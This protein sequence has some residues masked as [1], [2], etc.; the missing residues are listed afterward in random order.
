MFKIVITLRSRKRKT[1]FNEH[2]FWK[3][4][5]QMR[6]RPEKLAKQ[7]S[8][9]RPC[10]FCFFF[11][12]NFLLWIEKVCSP[13]QHLDLELINWGPVGCLETLTVVK[14]IDKVPVLYWR[15]TD[16]LIGSPRLAHK[17]TTARSNLM[18]MMSLIMVCHCCWTIWTSLLHCCR[19]NAWLT[20]ACRTNGVLDLMMAVLKTFTDDESDV[21]PGHCSVSSHHLKLEFAACTST[22]L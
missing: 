18:M 6:R 9:Q 8:F 15:L 2:T 4:E 13:I 16:V 22:V 11:T 14:A 20:A 3:R 19:I 21:L 17:V 12:T 5:F 10:F 7:T 1:I